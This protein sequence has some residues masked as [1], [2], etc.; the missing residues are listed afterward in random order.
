[1]AAEAGAGAAGVALWIRARGRRKGVQASAEACCPAC[2]ALGLLGPK[3][4]G[5]E[6][7][8]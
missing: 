5:L 2:L 6:A 7:L 3:A 1:M 8:T 4:S